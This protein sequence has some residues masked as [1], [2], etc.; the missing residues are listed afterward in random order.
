[1]FCL[2]LGLILISTYCSCSPLA[3]ILLSFLETSIEHVNI[4]HQIAFLLDYFTFI[5][6]YAS[7]MVRDRDI[8]CNSLKPCR[9]F[10]SC[11]NTQ[12]AHVLPEFN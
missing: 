11:S 10:S 2:L 1:M 8:P 12:E 3:Y 7:D 4:N 9:C 5:T 6:L